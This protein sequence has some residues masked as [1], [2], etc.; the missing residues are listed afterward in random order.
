MAW[1]GWIAEHATVISTVVTAVATACVAWF[2]I[3]L[4]GATAGLRDAA[5][6]QQ[7]DTREA[8]ALTRDSLA[9]TRDEF[10]AT[11]RPEI[12]VHN[13]EAS[14]EQTPEGSALCA[15]FFVVN[16]GTSDATILDIG[17]RIFLSD[18]FNPGALPGLGYGGRPLPAGGVL[19][20]VVIPGNPL[21]TAGVDLEIGYGERG[22][23]KLWCV[24][25]VVY[26][27]SEGRRRE[28]GFCR[29]FDVVGERWVKEPGS[30]YEYAY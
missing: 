6:Q 15:Q 18:K 10:D 11:H 3:K 13:F 4:T 16:K 27:D 8:L 14:R 2:T 7:L 17:G 20:D 30:D 23:A 26:E 25:R 28:T 12:I 22:H 19:R 21:A 29:S 5:D 24:G 9:L 1:V